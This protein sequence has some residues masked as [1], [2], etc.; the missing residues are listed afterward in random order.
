M[1][2]DLFFLKNIFFI[3]LAA[4]GL[5]CDI[6]ACELNSLSYGMWT[7]K[8]QH[9]GFSNL[10]RDWTWAPSTGSTVTQP[11]DHQGSP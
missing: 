1:D 6:W 10:I 9:V 11:L 3:Y 7:P 5:T 4:P 8:L 2:L